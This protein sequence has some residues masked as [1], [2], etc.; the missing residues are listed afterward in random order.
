MI[1]CSVGPHF[2]ILVPTHL[3]SRQGT[4]DR[5][6]A[7]LRVLDV[8]TALRK[9][10]HEIGNGNLFLGV[11]MAVA[12]VVLRRILH[13]SAD[14]GLETEGLILLE[15]HRKEQVAQRRDARRHD[16]V[17]VGRGDDLGHALAVDR[18][19][20]EH[21]AGSDLLVEAHIELARGISHGQGLGT[22]L[23]GTHD[24]RC[25]LGRI[26]LGKFVIGIASRRQEG[27]HTCE[28]NG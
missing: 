3:V 7:G 28:K 17:L 8:R 5:P 19:D 4:D 13:R 27:D 16:I 11:D 25:R 14:Q 12:A 20:D 24:R 23:V 21:M 26:E 1:S 9:G 10:H 22:H 18:S 2:E 6:V 15:T